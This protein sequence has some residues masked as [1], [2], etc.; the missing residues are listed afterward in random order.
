MQQL[1]GSV[2]QTLDFVRA[3]ERAASF[4]SLLDELVL[5]GTL[6]DLPGLGEMLGKEVGLP[7]RTLGSLDLRLGFEIERPERLSGFGS[8]LA[9]GVRGISA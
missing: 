6:A 1:V 5:L 3:Q 9:L 2:L 4:Q 7:A 8:A